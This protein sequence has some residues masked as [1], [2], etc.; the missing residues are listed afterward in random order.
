MNKIL[1][2]SKNS[3][4][5]RMFVYILSDG[6]AR[7]MPFLVFPVVAYYL[8][9]EEYGLVTNFLVL[10]SILNAFVGLNT[11]TSLSV[12]YYKKEINKANLISNLTYLNFALSVTILGVV[13]LFNK[14]I[15]EWTG[16]NLL[17]QLL[18]VSMSFLHSVLQLFTTKLRLDEKAKFFGVFQ[19]LRSLTSASLTLLFVAILHWSWQG[20]IYSLFLGT[21]AGGMFGLFFFRKKRIYF[22]KIDKKS[23]W[24]FLL[25]GIPL[26][27]HNV[28][29]WIKSGFD[30]IFITQA[31][32]LSANGI[33]S[34]AGTISAI[35]I[36]FSAAFFNAFT[37]Y[38]MKK[39][40]FAEE[41]P[42][43]K[44]RIHKSLVLKSYLFALSYGFVLLLGY[45]AS[46]AFINIFFKAKYGESITYLPYFLG[47]NWFNMVY[48]IFSAYVFYKKNTKYL[49][50][51]TVA[52]SGI[53]VIL[54]V[55]FVPKYG[56]VGAGISML[57]VSIL[58][59]IIVGI[60]SYKTFP[61][62]WLSILRIKK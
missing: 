32:D 14:K 26:I 49:G 31:I 37:P 16:L 19:F 47:Y 61:M 54:T 25:F 15:E 20:R 29:F 27:P 43:E 23:L 46:V 7:A 36:L 51:L 6:V 42:N 30:K 22:S 45:F 21:F 55:V 38:L 5:K 53:Q 17:W 2:L 62:P 56:P 40:S 60:Y 11:Q 3:L 10:T 52:A 4:L 33:Y 28:A 59:A 8:S 48:S 58:I 24:G 9:T 18:G 13:L 34:F 41:H 35:F 57:V 44:T 1:E 12:D 50:L 39:L